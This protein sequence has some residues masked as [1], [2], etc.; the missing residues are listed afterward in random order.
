[1]KHQKGFTLI[2]LLV[3]IAIIGLLATLAV[4]AFGSAREKARDTRRITDIVA[5]EQA[6]R[7]YFEET[8][9][10]PGESM[11]GGGQISQDCDNAFRNELNASGIMG[12][13]PKD[14]Q[15]VSDC[16]GLA[17]NDADFFYGYDADHAGMDIC[18]SINNLETADAL[19]RL[20]QRYGQA[21]SVTSGA[22]TNID[23]AAFNYCFEPD[24]YL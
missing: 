10:Y 24:T 15:A 18:I 17:D 6:M 5:I 11:V 13:V 9:S 2:E 19:N 12:V 21:Q 22:D 23:Q 20:I 7:L 14:P 4:V 3:V 8:G 1:M 16:T